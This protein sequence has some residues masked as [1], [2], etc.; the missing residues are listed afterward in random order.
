MKDELFRI[1]LF[2]NPS[3][4]LICLLRLSPN[5]AAA[6][7]RMVYGG[8]HL[9]KEDYTLPTKMMHLGISTVRS[10]NTWWNSHMAG[11]VDNRYIFEI[12]LTR[13]FRWE[14]ANITLKHPL[15]DMN[16]VCLVVDDRSNKVNSMAARGRI[17][18]RNVAKIRAHSYEITNIRTIKQLKENCKDA[19]YRR[20]LE[21]EFDLFLVD[22]CL[23]T[24]VL[25]F[26]GDVS[27]LKFV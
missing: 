22:E 6:P 16:T 27:N 12:K 24:N 10:S 8:K 9:K 5:R 2:P 25:K 1:E 17:V 21:N 7:Q 20:E 26:L 15:V 18:R 19:M 3:P 13:M 11:H 23:K 4:H 14:E